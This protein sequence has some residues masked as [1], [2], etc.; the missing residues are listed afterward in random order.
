MAV[1]HAPRTR[2]RSWLHED[3]HARLKCRARDYDEAWTGLISS[4][5]DR[6]AIEQPT[7]AVGDPPAVVDPTHVTVAGA[8]PIRADPPVAAI[9]ASAIAV[10]AST[11]PGTTATVPVPMATIPA[12]TIARP[13]VRTRPRATRTRPRVRTRPGL[14]R[15]D[16]S[17][18][19]GW[20]GWCG[21]RGQGHVRAAGWGGSGDK[22]GR[23][24][25]TEDGGDGKSANHRS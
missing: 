20:R 17:G 6:C 18:S 13:R 9:P 2:A 12:G 1:G 14:P 5:S 16:R 15:V 23:R 8:A 22:G 25:G 21:H 10:P 3:V 11:V 24:G 4:E 19:G 7:L